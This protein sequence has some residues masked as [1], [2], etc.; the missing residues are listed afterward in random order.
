M[1][2]VQEIALRLCAFVVSQCWASTTKTQRHK[3]LNA[4]GLVL[5]FREKLSIIVLTGTKVIRD[6]DIRDRTQQGMG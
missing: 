1:H 3:E 6:Y 4:D 5:Q 2:E